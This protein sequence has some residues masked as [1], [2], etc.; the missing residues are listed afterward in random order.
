MTANTKSSSAC[1]VFTIRSVA[2]ASNSGDSSASALTPLPAG[3]HL[4][5]ELSQFGLGSSLYGLGADQIENTASISTL[6]GCYGWL[7]SDIPDT[8]DVFTGRYQAT[9]CS[10]SR[11]MHSNGYARCNTALYRFTGIHSLLFVF[12]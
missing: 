10:F 12:R 4:T 6:Y 2:T 5:T 11:S 8:V 3:Y 7:P 9:P 1:S